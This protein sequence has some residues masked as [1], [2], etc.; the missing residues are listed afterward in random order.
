MIQLDFLERFSAFNRRLSTAAAAIKREN[1][2]MKQ[3]KT[4]QHI[5]KH[6]LCVHTCA[7]D[8]MIQSR[9]GVVRM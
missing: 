6:C 9:I 8:M 5:C 2:K 7:L 1:D 3:N 4:K